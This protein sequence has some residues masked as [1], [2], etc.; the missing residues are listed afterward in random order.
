M[1]P[2]GETLAETLEVMG[3]TQVEL[4]RRAGR[5]V[6]AISEIIREK[7]KITAETA[8]DLERVLGVSARVWLRLE[9]D[10]RLINARLAER[11]RLKAKIKLARDCH[12]RRLKT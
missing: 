1:I 3:I 9:A 7:K 5:P 2:P 4:A 11:E 8:L 10:F 6:Q 12:I